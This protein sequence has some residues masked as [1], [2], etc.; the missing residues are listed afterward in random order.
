MKKDIQYVQQ[1]YMALKRR[2]TGDFFNFYLAI[3]FEQ[4][5]YQ[6]K[7]SKSSMV[8]VQ[9]QL[10]YFIQGFT[11]VLLSCMGRKDSQELYIV[12]TIQP[13]MLGSNCRPIELSGT[14]FLM[15]WQFLKTSIF[16]KQQKLNNALDIMKQEYTSLSFAFCSSSNIFIRF[17]LNCLLCWWTFP[18]NA[19]LYTAL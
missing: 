13:K 6:F 19:L 18:S 8:A 3:F 12:A 14:T 17:S 15:G 10:Q 5:K 16:K 9:Y 4:N 2:I 1:C 7:C 11:Y